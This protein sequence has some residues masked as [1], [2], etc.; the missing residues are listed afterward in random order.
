LK[1][2]SSRFKSFPLFVTA[3]ALLALISSPA[4]GLGQ[5]FKTRAVHGTVTD[6]RGNPL[7]GAV[8]QIENDRTLEIASYITRADG[9]YHFHE[10]ST[11]MDY[12]LRAHYRNKWSAP[13]RLDKF[14][15]ARD[16]EINLTIPTE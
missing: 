4:A 1:I 9:T 14:N 12:T 7:K 13:K 15:S 8:V 5:Q 6:R 3:A 11:D 2:L 10:L 16:A